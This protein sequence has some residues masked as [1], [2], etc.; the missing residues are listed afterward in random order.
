M[1]QKVSDCECLENSQENFNFNLE[2]IL[3]KLQVYNAKAI[4]T[5]VLSQKEYCEEKVCDVYGVPAF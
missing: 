4:S 3:V 2:F 1:L 5:K